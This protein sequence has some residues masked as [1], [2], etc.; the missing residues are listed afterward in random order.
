[1][2]R[3]KI[4]EK[5]RERKYEII[6]QLEKAL[7]HVKE[8]KNKTY[9]GTLPHIMIKNLETRVFNTILEISEM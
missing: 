8:A 9:E 6:H 5:I 7:E 4:T 1:M 2:E 3:N